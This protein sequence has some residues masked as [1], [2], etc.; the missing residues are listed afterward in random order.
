MRN[1]TAT[2][3][4]SVAVVIQPNKWHKRKVVLVGHVRAIKNNYIAKS[5]KFTPGLTIGPEQS[6]Q[7]PIFINQVLE[8]KNQDLSLATPSCDGSPFE[9]HRWRLFPACRYGRSYKCP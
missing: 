5:L 4:N 7:M 1:N 9:H 8:E 6:L 2:K 3:Y